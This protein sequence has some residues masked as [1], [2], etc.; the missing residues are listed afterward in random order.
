MKLDY[1]GVDFS[2]ED[3]LASR[4]DKIALRVTKD[5]PTLDAVF[6]NVGEEG[7]GKTNTSIIEAA[8]LHMK[9]N[10]PINLFFK[11]SSC[12]DFAKRTKNQIIILDEPAFETMSSDH[13]TNIAK[14]LLRLTT[15]MR[16]KRH[17]VII[18]LTKFEKFPE[19][20]TT[21]R[22]IFM[23]WLKV[24]TKQGRFL[25]LPKKKLQ[26]LWTEY[27]KT[28]IKKYG[29]YKLFGGDF[30]YRMPQLLKVLNIHIEGKENATFEDYQRLRDEAVASIGEKKI[31]KKEAKDREDLIELRYRIAVYLKEKGFSYENEARYFNCNPRKLYEWRKRLSNPTISLEKEGFEG[32]AADPLVNRMGTDQDSEPTTLQG[33]TSN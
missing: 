23:L 13:A 30:S 33:S 32:S 14:D 20:L 22:A 4:L 9:T 11:T 17:T 8:Y 12:I 31:G 18:N 1:K 29:K 10:R 27:Q 24:G 6:L 5:H 21:S 16:E 7:S 3:K 28:H 2:I 25:Y 26:F 15:T 19:W